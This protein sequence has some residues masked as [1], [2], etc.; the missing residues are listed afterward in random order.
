MLT[1][2]FP[3]S[4]T[5]CGY[6]KKK[7]ASNFIYLFFSQLANVGTF[8]LFIHLCIFERQKEINRGRH[9]LKSCFLA[10]SANAS[11]S[12]DWARLKSVI[13][14]LSQASYMC[15][16]NPATW[17]STCCVL[18]TYQQEAGNRYE[19]RTQTEALQYG[20][21]VDHAAL[22]LMCQMTTKIFVLIS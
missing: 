13:L 8:Y 16:R 12:W 14:N 17:A 3:I 10:H 20:M 1:A 18:A 6:S 5:S 19:A 21:W 11:I 9:R 2:K 7:N 22:E 15:G 4:T